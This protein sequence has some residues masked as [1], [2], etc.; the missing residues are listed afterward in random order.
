MAT[1]TGKGEALLSWARQWP[2]LDGM[3]KLNAT[4]TESGDVALVVSPSNAPLISYI[5]G[6]EQNAISFG[7]AAMLPYSSF[8]DDVNS[9]A[10]RY[11]ES[12]YDWVREQ[13]DAENYPDFG[14]AIIDSVRPV[15][16]APTVATVYNEASLAKYQ[17]QAQIIYTE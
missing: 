12:W 16:A 5:D 11:M 8:T 10:Q 14:E 17:F 15:Q 7:L 1:L 4:V 2:A 13:D 9:E 6:K 3:L